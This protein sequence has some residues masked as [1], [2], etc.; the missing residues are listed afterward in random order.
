MYLSHYRGMSSLTLLAITDPILSSQ[1]LLS[2]QASFD[3]H[4]APPQQLAKVKA[5]QGSSNTY[6]LQQCRESAAFLSGSQTKT[7][8]PNARLPF[9]FTSPLRLVSAITYFWNRAS[10]IECSPALDQ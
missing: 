5:Q 1:Q 10:S 8:A 4:T 2:L 9:C 7:I 6:V 3:E